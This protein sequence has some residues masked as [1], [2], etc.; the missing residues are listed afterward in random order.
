MA[1]RGIGDT[2]AWA[3]YGLWRSCREILQRAN[4]QRPDWS[5]KTEIRWKPKN[6]SYDRYSI[7]LWD[8]FPKAVGSWLFHA[9]NT[10]DYTSTEPP[11][12]N[13]R[14]LA[15][16]V[17]I[18]SYPSDS[19]IQYLRFY[20]SFNTCKGDLPAQEMGMFLNTIVTKRGFGL[21]RVLDLEG[22]Y[23]PMLPKILR[24]FLYLN[25]L[26]LRWTFL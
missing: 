23:K 6:L 21:L 18:K 2:L 4:H 7:I 13:V 11:K 24:K 9:H 17:G 3:K 26:G 14:R 10:T 20:I 12:F 15:E 25:Y 5:G 1:C 19:Y 22:V 16:Y 8:F